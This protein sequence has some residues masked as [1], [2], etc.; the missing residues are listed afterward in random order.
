MDWGLPTRSLAVVSTGEPVFRET[1]LQ[2]AV[3]TRVAMSHIRVGTF[4]YA[5]ACQESDLVEALLKYAIERRM[6]EITNCPIHL[7]QLHLC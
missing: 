6:P 2:G 1:E 7:L 5:A 4:E 3:L